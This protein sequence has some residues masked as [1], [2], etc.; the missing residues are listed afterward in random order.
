MH[1]THT[2]IEESK[3]PE[4]EAAVHSHVSDT[5]HLP[6]E[7]PATSI[8]SEYEVSVFRDVEETVTAVPDIVCKKMDW[9]LGIW[10]LSTMRQRKELHGF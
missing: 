7:R 6:S 4:K 1:N 10:L 8:I 9:I 3:V 5:S 2:S